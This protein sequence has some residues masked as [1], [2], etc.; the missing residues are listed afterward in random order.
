M[1]L[2]KE[3]TDLLRR[4][5]DGSMAN[6]AFRHVDHVRVAWAYLVRDGLDEA[7]RQFPL[8]LL[9]FATLKGRPDIF[10]PALTDDWLLVIEAARRSHPGSTFDELL[11]RRPELGDKAT[12]PRRS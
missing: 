8:A 11:A 3:H 4:F 10:D 1:T 12:V 9:R 7:R 5:G 6:E 2:D